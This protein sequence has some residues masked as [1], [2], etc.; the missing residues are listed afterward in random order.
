MP[1]QAPGAPRSTTL[2]PGQRGLRGRLVSPLPLLRPPPGSPALMPPL[3]LF[4]DV[5]GRRDDGRTAQQL[6]AGLDDPVIEVLEDLPDC[7]LGD[8]PGQT[9]RPEPHSRREA[10]APAAPAR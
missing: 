5:A 10:S 3:D 4:V 6:P 8:S 9:S 7:P 1:P 2:P